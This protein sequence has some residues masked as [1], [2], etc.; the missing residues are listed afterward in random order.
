MKKR[1]LTNQ[2]I[3]DQILLHIEPINSFYQIAL[4]EFNKMR[5]NAGFRIYPRLKADFIHNAWVEAAKPYFESKGIYIDTSFDSAIINFCPG[6]SAKFKKLDK[7]HL[8]RPAKTDRW[9]NFV[10]GVQCSFFPEEHPV[11]DIPNSS[12]E[13]G[14][15]LD[16][17]DENYSKMVVVRRVDADT[18]VLLMHID[19][20]VEKIQTIKASEVKVADKEVKIV[21]K[22]TEGGKS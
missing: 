21:F 3:C 8:S 16:P 18:A 19:Q 2:E 7:N 1:G 13:M 9:K 15:D 11:S 4:D 22:K 6:L 12:V 10:I 5:N 20:E 17:S 14:Y